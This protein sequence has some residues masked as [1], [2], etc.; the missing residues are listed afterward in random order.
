MV[1]IMCGVFYRWGGC[2]VGGV[3]NKRQRLN[4]NDLTKAHN[5][6]YIKLLY[7]LD[8]KG[9]GVMASSHEI[10]GIIQD[11]VI[12]YRDEVHKKSNAGAK[13]EELKD[14]AVAAIFG[15]ASI[16]TDGVDW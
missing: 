8:Q 6:V 13:I 15:I 16:Q 2:G 3:R 5:D 7:R 11:E 10:L 12:E 14:I 4:L 9:P 1:I